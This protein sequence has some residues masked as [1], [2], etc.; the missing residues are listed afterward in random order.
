MGLGHSLCKITVTIT[1]LRDDTLCPSILPHGCFHPSC[2]HRTQPG[3]LAVWEFPC[4]RFVH[5]LLWRWTQR[6]QMTECHDSCWYLRWNSRVYAANTRRLRACAACVH[7]CE[8][9]FQICKLQDEWSPWDPAWHKQLK[10]RVR[11]G[12]GLSFNSGR[13]R[14][15]TIWAYTD[16]HHLWVKGTFFQ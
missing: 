16:P 8:K 1:D 9:H 5:S 14:S 4:L 15:G 11:N 7:T 6:T 12:L 13:C 10:R 3:P 2:L